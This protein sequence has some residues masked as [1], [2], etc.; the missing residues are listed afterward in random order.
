MTKAFVLGVGND[1]EDPSLSDVSFGLGERP[2]EK[3]VDGHEMRL[4]GIVDAGGGAV[5]VVTLDGRSGGNEWG[6]DPGPD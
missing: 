6:A 2:R 3:K 5:K 1:G 4:E